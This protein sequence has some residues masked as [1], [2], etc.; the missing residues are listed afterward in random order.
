MKEQ[1]SNV[2][3][4]YLHMFHHVKFCSNDRSI[5]AVQQRLGNRKSNRKQSFLDFKFSINLNRMTYYYK[6]ETQTFNNY[7]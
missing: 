2:V 5:A 4:I 7:L 1:Q 6:S 3:L